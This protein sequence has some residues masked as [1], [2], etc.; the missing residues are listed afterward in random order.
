MYTL[1]LTRGSAVMEVIHRVGKASLIL[2]QSWPPF[3]VT[4][5]SPK[6]VPQKITRGSIGETEMLVMVPYA[7]KL[8]SGVSDGEIGDQNAPLFVDLYSR[9]VPRYNVDGC[10]GSKTNGVFQLLLS[11][12]NMPSVAFTKFIP[13]S[14]LLMNAP[15]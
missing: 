14:V 5:A 7:L 6:S 13:P 2:F 3:N 1:L 12:P 4:Q 9:L 15:Y 8:V 11:D 10:F